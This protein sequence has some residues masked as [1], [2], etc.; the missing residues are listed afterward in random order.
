MGDVTSPAAVRCGGVLMGRGGRP[1]SGAGQMPLSIREAAARAPRMPPCRDLERAEET[2]DASQLLASALLHVGAYIDD[3][4]L[5][6]GAESPLRA[7][8]A[9]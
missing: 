4:A 7:L 9:L 2:V 6:G 1:L 8:A 5:G 3:G